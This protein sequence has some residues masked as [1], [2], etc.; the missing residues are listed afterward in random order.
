MFDLTQRECITAGMLGVL[1]IVSMGL[2]SWLQ[3]SAPV[4]VTQRFVIPQEHWH[5][6][7]D[8]GSRID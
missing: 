1:L 7:L 4:S 3:R 2:Q 6:L 8:V 5:T